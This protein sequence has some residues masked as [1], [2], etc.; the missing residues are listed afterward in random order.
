MTWNLGQLG[1]KETRTIKVTAIPTQLGQASDCLSVDFKPTLCTTTQVTKPTLQITKEG[2]QQSYL[3]DEL[4]YRYEVTNT[5]TG[6]ARNVVIRDTLAPGMTS[7]DGKSV[8]EHQM[9]DIPAGESRELIGK[10][11]PSDPGRYASRAEARSESAQAFSNEVATRIVEPKLA[12]EVNGPEWQLIDQPANYTVRVTNTSDVTARQTVVH[13]EAPGLEGAERIQQLGDLEPGQ[14][15]NIPVTL[16]PHGVKEIKVVA[17]AESICAKPAEQQVATAIR[18]MPALRLETVD[19]RDPVPSGET[20]VYTISVKN[21]GSAPAKN[22]QIT[23]QVPDQLEVVSASGDTQAQSSGNE[24]K[25]AP[26]QTLAPGEE[27]NWQVEARAKQEGDVRMKVQL[28]SDY[29][30]QPVSETEPTRLVK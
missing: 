22:V 26:M 23:A 6:V 15:R 24:M 11:K 28:N 8:I 10:M 5:G 9:G 27:V 2:P 18:T 13:L 14:S 21:Q 30:Q 7:I 25:F 12:V 17:R 19:N 29:L 3:C 16:Y 4:Q 20:T 1:P